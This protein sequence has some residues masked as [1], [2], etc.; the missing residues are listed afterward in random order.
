MLHGGQFLPTA[1]YF[2]LGWNPEICS[3]FQILA[4]DVDVI[5]IRFGGDAQYDS[6]KEL[7]RVDEGVERAF[8]SL[9]P[10][11]D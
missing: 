3:L 6:S 7:L 11:P 4:S 8:K 10:P 5:R 9:T 1:D 2:S